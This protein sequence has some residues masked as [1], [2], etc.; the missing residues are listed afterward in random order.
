[1]RREEQIILR[2]T[3]FWV[4]V[5]GMLQQN[6]AVIEDSE[7]NSATVP[8]VSDA[9][10][11]FDRLEF[12]STQDAAAALDHNGFRRHAGDESLAFLRPPPGPFVRGEH[13]NGPIYS[14]GR[15]WR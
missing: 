12:L 7:G 9:S 10:R 3:E 2:S 13:P 11:V 6:W 5:V 15:F 8:F 1:M 4:K 14:S